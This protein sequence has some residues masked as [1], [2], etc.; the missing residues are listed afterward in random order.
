MT[1]QSESPKPPSAVE[2]I[3]AES[4]FLRGTLVEDI[5]NESTGGISADNAQ[6]TKFHGLYLQ[7]DRDE[8]LER[9]KAKLERA[10]SFMMRIRVPGGVCT[11]E[12]YRMIDDLA[13]RFANGTV[14]L[15]TRQAFQLHGLLK[16]NVKPVVQHIQK[17]GMDSIAACG[18]VNR[19]VMTNPFPQVSGVHAEACDLARQLSV[20]LT[21][22]SRA[23]YEIWLDEEKVA[24]GEEEHEPI[25]GKTYLPRKFKIGIAVPP[26]N[27]IDVFSQDLGFIA[28]VEEGKITGYNVVAGGGLGKTHGKTDTYPRVA[29]VIGYCRPDQ[30]IQVAE[31]VVTTQR[32]YG[33]RS[34]RRHAR[35]KYTIA[36]RGVEWFRGEVEKRAGLKFGEARP[37]QFE[38]QADSYRWNRDV[39]GNWYFVLFILSGRIKDTE[40]ATMRSGV[41][42]I[43][44]IHQGEFRL[45]ANQNLMITGISDEKKTEI[46]A[47]LKKHNIHEANQQ[48]AL[49]LNAMSCPALPT[50]GLALAESERFM[51]EFLERLE[52]IVEES[53]LRDDAITVRMTGCPNGC[54]RPYLAEIGLVGKAPGKYNLYL[55]AAFDGTR[56]NEEVAVAQTPDEIIDT[57]E[58]LIRRYARER[59]DGE[60]FGDFCH[61]IEAVKPVAMAQ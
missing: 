18:D 17:V 13:G 35:L 5:Q 43:A 48:S 41:R 9:R 27:D 50:C 25:Y 7:D 14:R 6:L 2:K 53:G 15:T 8:R 59:A 1:S 24:G 28:I 12:Q 33:D 26:R 51:P 4:R 57:I 55:G 23:Y 42:E 37:V 31:A 20:H 58:P 3:K 10:F 45:T 34:D 29:D 47:I 16:G 36:D 40:Q 52:A 21:P 19:N 54:A 39:H 32:D 46:E 38:T 22:R 11:T 30:V 61:R 56:L 60:R 44:E 49:R